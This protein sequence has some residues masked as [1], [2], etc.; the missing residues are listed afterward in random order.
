MGNAINGTIEWLLDFAQLDGYNI[1]LLTI[2]LAILQGFLGFFPFTTIIMLHISVLGLRNGLMMSWL[3]G[4]IAS[5]VAF[6]FFRYI[7]SGWVNQ[8]LRKKVERYE[9]WQAYFQ[10]YGV[11]AIIFLRTLPI[12]PNSLVSFMSS[13]SPIKSIPYLV[14]SI[15]GNLSNIWLFGIISSKILMPKTDIRMLLYTYIGFCVLLCVLFLALH[16]KRK[17]KTAGSRPKEGDLHV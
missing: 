11:W 5:M 3:T 2:P 17:I 6:Y 15:F 12:M 4:T 7:F 16:S 8:R 13:V 1:L 9:K 10:R 14:S